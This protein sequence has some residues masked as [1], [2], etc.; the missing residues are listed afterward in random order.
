MK[1]QILLVVLCVSLTAILFA[2]CGSSN[3]VVSNDVNTE[4]NVT[5]S[6]SENSVTEKAETEI[7]EEKETET[8]TAAS[9]VI[10]ENG[11]IIIQQNTEVLPYSD[12]IPEYVKADGGIAMAKVLPNAFAPYD[13]NG[14]QIGKDS[15]MEYK[16]SNDGQVALSGYNEAFI[17]DAEG[18]CLAELDGC[19]FGGHATIHL[20]DN[21]V[22]FSKYLIDNIVK[23]Y[24]LDTKETWF[25]ASGAG[26]GVTPYENGEFY[27][28][29]DGTLYKVS[30]DGTSEKLIDAGE[31]M[32]TA[33]FEDGYTCLIPTVYSSVL[34]FYNK[35]TN[36]IVKADIGELAELYLR[37]NYEYA[38]NREAVYYYDNGLTKHNN[39]TQF[40]WAYWQNRE[41]RYCLVDISRA[42]VDADG[43]LEMT[44]DMILADYDY[45]AMSDCGKYL[46]SDGNWYFY[47]DETGKSVGPTYLDCSAFYNGYAMAIDYDDG[48]AYVIDA[49][50]EKVSKGYPADSVY[51]AGG[52]FVITKG[53]EKT[54]L[55]PP[56]K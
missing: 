30:R 37:G 15:Y 55:A 11:M 44:K 45:I 25:E 42:Q 22:T 34:S 38:A 19:Q 53:E 12:M 48:K 3:D 8:E 18:N 52:M 49:N 46:A 4:S 26:A 2:G 29:L 27:Y 31:V 9:A 20:N 16:M 33:A 7:T 28:S 36:E 10:D 21:C 23:A 50:F 56:Q 5:E 51:T 32:F 24:D 39:G 40:I 54:L 6:K 17:Y 41:T 13:Y 43:N 47:I 1:K 14:V 35:D